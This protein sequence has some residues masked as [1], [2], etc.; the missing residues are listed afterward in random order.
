MV[1]NANFFLTSWG[2]CNHLYWKWLLNPQ[3]ANVLFQKKFVNLLHEKITCL[4]TIYYK[5]ASKMNEIFTTLS[6]WF[7]KKTNHHREKIESQKVKPAMNLILRVR[8]KKLRKSWIAYAASNFC[9]YFDTFLLWARKF[10]Y[11]RLKHYS[12]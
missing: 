1:N 7:T 3:L 8:L 11:I 9:I 6:L 10:N 5:N 4:Q 2:W 12:I